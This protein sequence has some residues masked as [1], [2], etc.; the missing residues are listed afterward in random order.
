MRA[1]AKGV[2]RSINQGGCGPSSSLLPHSADPDLGLTPSPARVTDPPLH[3]SSPTHDNL[4]RKRVH[5]SAANI[6]RF[7]YILSNKARGPAHFIAGLTTIGI[8]IAISFEWYNRDRI[9]I[10]RWLN[11][12][13]SWNRNFSLRNQVWTKFRLCT[14]RFL[15]ECIINF[16]EKYL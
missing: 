10:I 6:T 4:V 11:W 12:I 16:D 13:C 14:I 7:V 2:T 3:H 15:S 5:A 8:A 1:A 9:G